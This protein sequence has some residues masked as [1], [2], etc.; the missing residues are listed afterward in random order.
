[1]TPF[2][3]FAQRCWPLA[4]TL[5]ATTTVGCAGLQTTPSDQGSRLPPVSAEQVGEIRPGSGILKGYLDRKELPNSLALRTAGNIEP[6]IH[7]EHQAAFT[8]G[9]KCFFE[10]GRAV[11]RLDHDIADF[12]KGYD[13][14]VGERGLKLS[15]GEKQRVAIARA[16]VHRPKILILDEP[17]SALDVETEAEVMRGMRKQADSAG[18]DPE[19]MFLNLYRD[20]HREKVRY[21]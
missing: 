18:V 15:G 2:I 14:S 17:T 13:T 6:E 8:M 12:P 9:L 19:G 20:M 11:A 1:M 7:P 5:V 10:E 16:L 21:S 3:T 4:A